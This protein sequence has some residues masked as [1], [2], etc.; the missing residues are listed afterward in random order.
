MRIVHYHPRA[1]VGDGGVSNSVRRL[2]RALVA[3]GTPAVIAYDAADGEPPPAAGETWVPVAHRGPQQLRLPV[4]LGTVLRPGDVTVLVSAWTAHNVRAGQVAAEAGVPYVLAPRGAYDPLIMRRRRAL[5]RAWWW[6]AERRLV[7]RAAALHVFFDRQRDHVRRLG[8]RGRILV[9]PNG[10]S[11]P[12]DVTWTPQ[13]GYLLYLGRFDP[14]HKGLDLLLHA[15]AALPREQRP[16]LRLHGPDWRGGKQ[17]VTDLVAALGLG[18]WVTV[19]A[20]LYG[21]EKWAVLRCASGFVYPSRWEGFGNSLAEAAAIGVPC[22]ATPYPLALHLRSRDACLVVE[23]DA[24]A[25]ALGLRR[26]T[27][28]AQHASADVRGEFQWAT[29]ARSWAEQAAVLA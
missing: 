17:V 26:L 8:Y 2:S 7:R 20:A 4:D 15:V 14:E 12:D 3:S 24:R 21:G 16:Q 29:V 9:A 22:L 1:R 5:K 28:E 13:G 19:G 6:A 25:L 10:V 11:V 27:T 23:P 18:D